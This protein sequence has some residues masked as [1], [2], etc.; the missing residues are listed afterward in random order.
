[1]TITPDNRNRHKRDK[2]ERSRRLLVVQVVFY[3]G[4]VLFGLW[5]LS[6]VVLHLMWDRGPLLGH[7]RIS[8][9]PTEVEI[10]HCYL[11][12]LTLFN[13]M[14]EDYGNVTA[15]TRC[16]RSSV[17]KTWGSI[18]A[19][20][21]HPWNVVRKGNPVRLKDVG[22]W[23][24]RKYQVWSRCRLDEA[25]LLSRTRSL[26]DLARVHLE[27]DKL[28]RVLTLQLHAHVSASAPLV[29]KIRRQLH[30]TFGTMKNKR[31][32]MKKWKHVIPARLR[33][34]GIRR[35]PKP[36]CPI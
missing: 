33:K 20:D 27:M 1:L 6:S 3:A 14:V 24:F 29:E 35:Q 30:S 17:K 26:A 11:D 9:K 23:R 12:T 21:A 8:K 5:F 7:G 16:E 15:R 36:I 13:V 32:L 34:W 4:V 22:V 18:Y 10:F 28:R 19:W 2:R 31:R 25:G